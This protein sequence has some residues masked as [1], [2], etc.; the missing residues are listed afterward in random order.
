MA[1]TTKKKRIRKLIKVAGRAK[2]RKN[3]DRKY[4]STAP[5]LPLNKPNANETAQIAAAGR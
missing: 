5:N 4:G 1:S 2:K 3:W